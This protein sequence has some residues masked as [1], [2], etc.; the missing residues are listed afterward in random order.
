MKTIGKWKKMVSVMKVNIDLKSSKRWKRK[1][2]VVERWHVHGLC[3]NHSE[4][5]LWWHFNIVLCVWVRVFSCIVDGRRCRQK[6][7]NAFLLIQCSAFFF[8]FI[9]STSCVH[10]SLVCH[11]L[12]LIGRIC[13][14][15]L[16]WNIF[17]F[18]S[19][20]ILL[21]IFQSY[22]LNFLAISFFFWSRR[23]CSLLSIKY[24]FGAF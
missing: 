3:E 11:W 18:V 17:F 24:A 13:V 15:V 14:D 12:T 8:F 16:V 6:I 19:S 4:Y 9:K 21:P 5:K 23:A 20:S 22:I 7:D 2:V 10:I 1:Y